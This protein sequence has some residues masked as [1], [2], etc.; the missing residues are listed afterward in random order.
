MTEKGAMT[1][2]VLNAFEIGDAC[3]SMDLARR[4]S[5]LPGQKCW[6]VNEE[7]EAGSDVELQTP[8]RQLVG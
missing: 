8:R 3:A 5:M 7:L 6:K 4:Q 2:I 1:F